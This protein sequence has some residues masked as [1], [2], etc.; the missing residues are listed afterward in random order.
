MKDARLLQIAEQWERAETDVAA[1]QHYESFVDVVTAQFILMR[2]EVDVTPTATDP[3]SSSAQMFEDIDIRGR[4]WVFEGGAPFPAGNPLS[5]IVWLPNGEYW[6][7][8]V[9]FRAVHDYYGHWNRGDARPFETLQGELDAW[10]NH[11]AS[12]PR[13][14]WGPLWTETVG[15]LAYHWKHKEFV[16]LQ[17]AVLLPGPWEV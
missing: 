4:L 14:V 15:Q 16:P 12:M 6:Q 11:R 5:D 1:I 13:R 17:K 3:Y 9:M 10:R 2:D 8:N 7:A